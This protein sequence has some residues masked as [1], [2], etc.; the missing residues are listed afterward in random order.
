MGMVKINFTTFLSNERVDREGL[1]CLLQHSFK[2]FNLL[3]FKSDK[4]CFTQ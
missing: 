1:V 2:R 4:H 3:F